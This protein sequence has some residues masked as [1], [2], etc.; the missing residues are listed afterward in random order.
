ML[1]CQFWP[2]GSSGE[3]LGMH[4]CHW[5]KSQAHQA[6]CRSLQETRLLMPLDLLALVDKDMVRFQVVQE[7]T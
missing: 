5:P 6:H 2:H 7:D 4:L 1:E 3:V